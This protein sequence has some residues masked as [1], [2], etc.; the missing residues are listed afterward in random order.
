MMT[1]KF[2]IFMIA[3]LGFFMMPSQAFACTAKTEMACCKKEVNSKKDKK[4][5]CK[6]KQSSKQKSHQGC[7]GGCKSISCNNST[8]FL[9]LS[10][11][12][13]FSLNCELFSFS[14]EK[15][16]FYYAEIFS[17]SDFSSIWLPPKIS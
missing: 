2:Y 5:C 12:V 13:S 14:T 9:G 10:A 16:N 11:P 15:Q 6:N 8:V 17:P 1:K 7:D 3:M 4:E